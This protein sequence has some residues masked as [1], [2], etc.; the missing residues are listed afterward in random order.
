MLWIFNRQLSAES[1]KG[2]QSINGESLI[3]DGLLNDLKRETLSSL[4]VVNTFCT[5][6][7]G[8][9][10]QSPLKKLKS[11]TFGGKSYS[12]VDPKNLLLS[13]ILHDLE[14]SI[15]ASRAYPVSRAL[16]TQ[17]KVSEALRAVAP[18]A[19]DLAEGKDPKVIM[20]KVIK[21]VLKAISIVEGA[22]EAPKD[23]LREEIKKGELQV[24]NLLLQVS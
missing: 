8:N 2:I 22:K 20:R 16:T 9:P 10:S 17:V 14:A 23:R 24:L 3:K 11:S 7:S 19:V 6:S 4:Q 12:Y 1:L 21:K 5:P 18:D 15:K 13:F